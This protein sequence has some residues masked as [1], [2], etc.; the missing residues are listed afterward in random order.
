MAA[1]NQGAGEYVH[2][3]PVTAQPAH[4]GNVPVHGNPP[5][6]TEPPSGAPNSPGA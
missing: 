4:G 2:G 6:V 1:P 5:V 3:V